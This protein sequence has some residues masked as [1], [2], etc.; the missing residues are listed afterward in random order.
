M[1]NLIQGRPLA[2]QRI[3]VAIIGNNH[4]KLAMIQPQ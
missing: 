3:Y 1:L 2:Y 4:A